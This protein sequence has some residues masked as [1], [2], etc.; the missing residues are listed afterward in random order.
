MSNNS[1]AFFFPDVVAAVG[2]AS[3]EFLIPI[4]YVSHQLPSLDQQ[5]MI[6]A[7]D[8]YER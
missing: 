3:F 2:F 4:L 1:L 8:I 7:N 6:G 5:M